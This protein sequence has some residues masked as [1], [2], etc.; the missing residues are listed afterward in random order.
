MAQ[1]YLLYAKVMCNNGFL[2]ELSSI[3]IHH[4]NE[5]ITHL[6]INDETISKSQAW[7]V[8]ID[9]VASSSGKVIQLD[10]SRED[11]RRLQPFI[12]E[13]YIE[14]E[15]RGYIYA[16]NLPI[17]T[18]PKWLPSETS[19]ENFSQYSL[20]RTMEIETSDGTIGKAGEFFINPQSE[21]ITHIIL[22]RGH[23][24]RQRDV[25]IPLSLVGHVERK[26]IHLKI[27]KEMVNTLT[28]SPFQRPWKEINPSDLDLLIWIFT[29]RDQAY[30]ALR[31]LRA[32]QL[33]N[34]ILSINVAVISMDLNGNI[35]LREITDINSPI[36]TTNSL[37]NGGM[38]N[39]LFRPDGLLTILEQNTHTKPENEEQSDN[40]FSNSILINIKKDIPSGS[41]AIMLIIEHRWYSIFRQAIARFDHV[42]FHRRLTEINGENGNFSKLDWSN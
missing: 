12:R 11:T 41:S 36:G 35:S 29:T 19:E 13:H 40:K 20:H 17:L 4:Q 27:E 8:P 37:V 5:H 2:G 24:W 14:R 31:T 34:R 3:V 39:F 9:M 32:Y 30:A 28:H 23:F 38:V 16:F 42:F 6:V 7:L 1:E 21:Q 10:L 22:Q 25:I 18:A 15:F 26:K 33:N